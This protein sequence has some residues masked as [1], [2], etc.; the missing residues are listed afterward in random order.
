M[1]R[2]TV[3]GMMLGSALL[4]ACGR[5][6]DIVPPREQPEDPRLKDFR[7]RHE[8][9]KDKDGAGSGSGAGNSDGGG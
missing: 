2:R 4:A 1:K 7:D 6:G 9:D 5:R 3:L 8:S